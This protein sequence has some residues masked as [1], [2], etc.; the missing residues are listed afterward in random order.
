MIYNYQGYIQ[1][2]LPD[3]FRAVRDAFFLLPLGKVYGFA[4][5]LCLKLR[6]RR[7]AWLPVPVVSVGNIS[8]GG[9][10]KTP[11]CAFLAENFAEK[12]R[13][14]VILT[15]GYKS[16]VKKYPHLV[17]TDDDPGVCGDEPLLLARTLAGKADVVVDPARVRGA[18]WALQKLKPDIFILDDGFQH[19]Q[20]NRNLD[21]VL[22]TPYD[23]QEGW[24]KVFPQ[25]LWREDKRA[26]GRADICLVNLWGR[27]IGEIKDLVAEKAELKKCPV[28]YL[29]MQVQ[30]VKN[31]DTGQIAADIAQRPYLLVTGVANPQKI[32]LSARDFLGYAP[33]SHM[34]LPDHHRFGP[35][36][37]KEM[38]V[39]AEKLGVK[40]I[41]CTSKDAVKITSPA[42]LR[43]WEIIIRPAIADMQENEFMKTIDSNKQPGKR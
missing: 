37:L 15:R 24:N 9:T 8:M 34:A 14:P 28:F 20:I 27:S 1:S 23:L 11:V 7:S 22:L 41:I 13:K 31:L 43:V 39:L 21:L 5:R 30:G 26:L 3:N 35:E 10:G 16:G 18:S 33:S 40:D 19:V 42:L 2:R 38:T 4:S 6:K 25:G 36:T 29:D 32:V 17:S 12:G